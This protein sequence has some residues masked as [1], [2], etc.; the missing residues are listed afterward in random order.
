ME[1]LN[2]PLKTFEV[3]RI[4]SSLRPASSSL[5]ATSVKPSFALRIGSASQDSLSDEVVAVSNKKGKKKKRKS[6]S[7]D[8]RSLAQVDSSD[9]ATPINPP[10]ST[11]PFDVETPTNTNPFPESILPSDVCNLGPAPSNGRRGNGPPI[12]PIYLPSSLSPEEGEEEEE[13]ER[14]GNG[15]SSPV[16]SIHSY[17]DEMGSST[18][19]NPSSFSS[20]SALN[21]LEGALLAT[22]SLHHSPSTS[23][24]PP[25]PLPTVCTHYNVYHNLTVITNDGSHWG[26][27]PYWQDAFFYFCLPCLFVCPGG[28]PNYSL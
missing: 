14:E 3:P 17:S 27:A 5:V 23:P 9:Q 16:D 22:Q 8:I 25:A 1:Y 18:L 28:H 11:N 20:S 6:P 15:S 21:A 7:P 12:G 4:D 24:L 10:V 26:E 19:F 2:S 13:E